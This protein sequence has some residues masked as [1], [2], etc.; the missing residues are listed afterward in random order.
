MGK[1]SKN[2]EEG[3]DRGDLMVG[4]GAL[5]QQEVS[6]AQT[7]SPTLGDILQVITASC[8]ALEMKIDTL[9]AEFGLLKDD[10]RPLAERVAT[11][12]REVA[13]VPATMT[14]AQSRLSELE[15][16]FRVLEQK[17]DDA[18]N[19]SRRNKI[20]ILGVPEKA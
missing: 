18:E 16:K 10:H 2:R 9:G 19:L 17:G 1:V 6:L 4:P 14:G 8:E 7:G 15:N 13:D 20:R 3:V 11:V 12:E 5:E